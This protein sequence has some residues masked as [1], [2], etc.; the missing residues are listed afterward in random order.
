MYPFG[1]SHCDTLNHFID[2]L[3]E[4]GGFAVVPG[5]YLVMQGVDKGLIANLRQIKHTMNPVEENLCF[6]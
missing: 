2:L 3:F 6:S 1:E 5:Y 4:K